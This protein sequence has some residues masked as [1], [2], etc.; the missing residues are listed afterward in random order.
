MK[1]ADNESFARHV[2]ARLGLLGD[3]TG[4]QDGWAGKRTRAALDAALDRARDAVPPA[5]PAPASAAFASPLQAR[6]TDVFGPAGHADCT[7]GRCELPFPFIIAWDPTQMVTRFSCHR[8]VAPALTSI[9]AAAATHYG[10]AQFEDLGLHRFGGCF[11][12]RPMR[13]GL[14]LST[15]AWGIAVDL[16]P[17]RNQLRWDSGRARLAK[18]DAAAFW[19]I[20]EAHGAVSLGRKRNFDWMHFQFATL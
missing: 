2:Q 16:D 18:P 14:N 5:T 20:V 10:R 3:Y 4:A 17:E 7:A 13:G 15:H 12:Y 9:F 11:N 19:A 1:A 8:M 6:L